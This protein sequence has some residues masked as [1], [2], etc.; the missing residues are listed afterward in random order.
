MRPTDP[1]DVGPKD[2]FLQS[3]ERCEGVGGF[4]DE[5]YR[6]FMASSEEVREKFKFTDFTQQ[7]RMLR[8]SLQLMA[9]GTAGDPKG[10]AELAAR[11]ETHSRAHLDIPPPLYDLWLEA[12]IATAAEMDSEWSGATESAWRRVLGIAIRHMV[13]KYDDF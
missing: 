9:L 11:A 4:L 12:L 6:R 8:R 2:V 10:L 13:T 5:F 3:L 1:G 7:K